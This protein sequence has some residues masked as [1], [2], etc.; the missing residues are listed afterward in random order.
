MMIQI[1]SCSRQRGVS[2]IEVLVTVAILAFGLMGVA[3]LLVKSAAYANMSYARTAVTQKIYSLTDRMR[4][5][6]T[7]VDG[8]NY[9]AMPGCPAGQNCSDGGCNPGQM[10]AYDLCQWKDEVNKTLPNGAAT[11]QRIAGTRAF[12]VGVT[13]NNP[14][15]SPLSYSL[16]VHP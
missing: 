2:I 3:G 12:T 5:N 1:L 7:G 6:P 15:G 8:G 13:W 9:D 14:N 10:A 4:A 11:V 16:N